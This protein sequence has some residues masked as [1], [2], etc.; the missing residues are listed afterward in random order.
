MRRIDRVLQIYFFEWVS[1]DQVQGS[2]KGK[3]GGVH[4]NTVVYEMIFMLR[5]YCAILSSL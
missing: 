4:F 1:R 2:L 5:N 3:G